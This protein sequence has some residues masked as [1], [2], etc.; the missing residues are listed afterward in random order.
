MSE[1]F[2]YTKEFKSLYLTAVKKDR[3]ALMTD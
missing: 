3:T 2:N 1:D